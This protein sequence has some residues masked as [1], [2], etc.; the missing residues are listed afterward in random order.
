M[1]E[2]KKFK[3]SVG[4][5][6][7]NTQ[8]PP[9]ARVP[10]SI[11]TPKVNSPIT[12]KLQTNDAQNSRNFREQIVTSAPP[13]VSMLRSPIDGSTIRHL[14]ESSALRPVPEG[15]A[16]RPM[17]EGSAIRH[18]QEGSAIRPI[19]NGSAIRNADRKNLNVGS[20]PPVPPKRLIQEAKQLNKAQ[21]PEEAEKKSKKEAQ[22]RK[23][24]SLDLQLPDIKS[25]AGKGPRELRPKS[26]K[27][28]SS[29]PG[30][31][32]RATITIDLTTQ[33]QPI[34]PEFVASNAHSPRRKT[35]HISNLLSTISPPPEVDLKVRVANIFYPPTKEAHPV[36]IP[37]EAITR[38]GWFPFQFLSLEFLL[39]MIFSLLLSF[40]IGEA[41]ATKLD[42]SEALFTS[43]RIFAFPP[44]LVFL[45][46]TSSFSSLP[47]PPLLSPLLSPLSIIENTARRAK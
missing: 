33:S 26:H 12:K 8:S 41:D 6:E 31:S 22:L 17:P 34:V 4:E 3:D 40:F 16:I 23:L 37:S 46:F 15:S 38:P 47:P 44:P 19:P 24:Q 43:V 5:L 21:E 11:N 32:P 13:K 36:P 7:T 39:N 10:N 2:L 35:N 18:I 1:R 20:A 45:L 27:R 30:I 42:F 28:K 25:S 9:K 14:Q 29:S